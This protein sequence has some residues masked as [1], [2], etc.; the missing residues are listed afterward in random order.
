G[1]DDRSDH[2]AAQPALAWSHANAE[3]GLRL[4]WPGG[5][6]PHRAADLPHRHLLAAAGDDPV[7][8]WVEYAVGRT[9]ECVEKRPQRVLADERGADRGGAAVALRR[10]DPA[11]RLRR[12]ERRQPPRQHRRAGTG[13]PRPVAG[14]RDVGQASAPP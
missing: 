6:E 1:G 2:R 7:I 11:E 13:D 3:P 5:T 12:I 4:V 10:V 8:R 14:D 9:V